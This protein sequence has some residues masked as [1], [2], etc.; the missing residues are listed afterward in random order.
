MVVLLFDLMIRP[1]TLTF[2][3]RPPVTP[4]LCHPLAL[5]AMG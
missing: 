5:N 2:L 4:C 3:P 1:L